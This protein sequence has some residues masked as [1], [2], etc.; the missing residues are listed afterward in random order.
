MKKLLALLLALSMMLILCACGGKSEAAQ[1]VDD[2][3]TAIGDFSLGKEE[4]IRAARELYDALSD[5]DKEDVENLALL[6]EHEGK[7]DQIYTYIEKLSDMSNY[8][9]SYDFVHGM[10]A[11]EAME[12]ELEAMDAD[13]REAILLV[14]A[15]EDE[16]IYDLFEQY[17]SIPALYCVNNTL[18][19]QPNFVISCPITGAWLVNDHG[20]FA[21]YNVW[22]TDTKDMDTALEQYQEYI[23]QYTT[24]TTNGSSFTFLDEDGQ[25]CTVLDSGNGI[26]QV[27]VPRF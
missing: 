25:T 13:V 19:A 10:E 26:L 20:N 2:A 8:F 1:A 27:R 16:D 12:A 3:I 11:L 7:L 5:S 24:V 14:S 4:D 15:H 18:Y 23:S 17:R 22:I 9:T 6:E 21:A